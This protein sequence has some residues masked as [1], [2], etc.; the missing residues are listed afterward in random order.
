[1][2]A[3]TRF[4]ND[5][6][7][8][9]MI[10]VEPD[11]HSEAE[12]GGSFVIK[13]LLHSRLAIPVSNLISVTAHLQSILERWRT[14]NSRWLTIQGLREWTRTVL[15]RGCDSCPL[16]IDKRRT[17]W[18]FTD[19]AAVAAGVRTWA[20]EHYFQSMGWAGTCFSPEFALF[21]VMTEEWR[22]QQTIT[23]VNSSALNYLNSVILYHFS[24]VL[25]SFLFLF[26]DLHCILHRLQMLYVTQYW[27]FLRPTGIHTSPATLVF[28]MEGDFDTD[29]PRP[30][31]DRPRGVSKAKLAELVT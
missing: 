18:I 19:A 17:R 14:Q 30:A 25:W 28:I 31:D 4:V 22:T 27:Q 8:V 9:G 23:K 5:C 13:V 26:S 6:I 24:F 29:A 3:T 11:Y 1:M 2:T 7:K 12:C 20:K 10:S 16:K 15:R 21:A